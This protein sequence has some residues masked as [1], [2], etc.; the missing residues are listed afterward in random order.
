MKKVD[1][2]SEIVGM[3]GGKKMRVGG[4]DVAYWTNEMVGGRETLVFLHGFRGEHSGLRFVAGELVDDYNVVL[5]DLPGW[6]KSGAFEGRH[7]VDGY[8]GFLREFLAKIGREYG[9]TSLP[10]IVAHSMGAILAAEFA[11]AHPEMI[12]D[13]LVLIS[14]ISRRR[15]ARWVHRM[16]Y[17]PVRWVTLVMGRRVAHRV[18]ASRALSLVIATYLTTA[19]DRG[20]RKKILWEHFEYSG[21]FAAAR[22]LVEGMK[23]STRHDV[24]GVAGEIGQRV[25]VVIGERDQMSRKGATRKAVGKMGDVVYAEVAGTGHLIV[26]EKPEVVAREMREFFGG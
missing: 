25:L 21:R 12:S 14:P 24:L 9:M 8:V 23:M 10:I 19:R 18:L 5:V 22:V 20:M 7:D 1:G 13:R 11:V 2:E 4:A 16:S 17:Y 15:V 26:Y 6:G 3:N